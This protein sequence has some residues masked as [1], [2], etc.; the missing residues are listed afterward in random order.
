MRNLFLLYLLV[1]VTHVSRLTTVVTS[2]NWDDIF[3][4]STGVVSVNASAAALL[5]DY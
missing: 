1:I 5:S 3:L 4:W 2:I